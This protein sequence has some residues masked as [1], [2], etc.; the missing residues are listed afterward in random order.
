MQANQVDAAVHQRIPQ[1]RTAHQVYS[2][3]GIVVRHTDRLVKPPLRQLAE[4]WRRRRPA[5]HQQNLTDRAIETNL[6]SGEQLRFAL[7]LAHPVPNHSVKD[8]AIRH[9]KGHV[10]H[11]P[12]T[13]PAEFAW[14]ALVQHRYGHDT[15]TG[16]CSTHCY[17]GQRPRGVARSLQ[18]QQARLFRRLIFA[19][20]TTLAAFRIFPIF[21]CGGSVDGSF[22]LFPAIC[23][24][25]A[26][27]PDGEG[28]LISHTRTAHQTP[29]RLI[30]L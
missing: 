3:R 14:Q 8:G 29:Q 27:S 21:I 28:S 17:L 25:H 10:S 24:Q 2:R 19:T 4:S 6:V 1:R 23:R 13:K 16:A 20:F 9:T 11:K 22:A 5:R 12:S 7:A 15:S 30:R 26:S 18:D